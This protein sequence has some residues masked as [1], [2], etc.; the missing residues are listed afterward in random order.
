MLEGTSDDQDSDQD[1]GRG[2]Q[3]KVPNFVQSFSSKS[4]NFIGKI[5]KKVKHKKIKKGGKMNTK[6]PNLKT[7]KIENVCNLKTLK[8]EDI[9]VKGGVK[10]HIKGV[11]VA[12]D[13]KK[14]NPPYEVNQCHIM[15]ETT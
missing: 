10:N 8:V 1:E 11:G 2:I 5:L 4:V 7:Q 13:I 12:N 9:N 14:Q 3:Y 6:L 15:S